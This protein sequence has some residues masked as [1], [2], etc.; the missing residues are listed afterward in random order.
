MD[1]ANGAVY[2]VAP[3]VFSELGAE[4]IV[5]ND[6]PNGGNINDGCGA[7]HPENLAKEVKRLRADIGFAFDGDADRLVVVDEN[8]KVVDGDA[9]LG[10]LATYLDENKM[11]DKRR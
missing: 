1:V 10:V 7:L 11:L 4:T 3:T 9:L 6:E 8:A 2:K 5:L